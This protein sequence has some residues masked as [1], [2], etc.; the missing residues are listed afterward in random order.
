M[1]RN[2]GSGYVT[3]Q[4][5]D[6][7]SIHWYGKIRPPY[8]QTYTF[9]CYYDD[10]IRLYIDNVL[11]LDGWYAGWSGRSVNKALSANTF[12]DIKIEFA[13]G[14]GNAHW[15]LYWASPWIGMAIVP[16]GYLWSPQR[17]GDNVNTVEVQTFSLPNKCT[18]SSAPTTH[19]AGQVYSVTVQSRD[20]SSVALGTTS[21][22]YSITFTRS[23]GGGP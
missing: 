18:F 6:S 11:I 19:I 16:S 8:S 12:Y 23:D 22:S 14:G 7:V 17:V 2:W 20:S 10:R 4:R 9:T 21:D 5:A 1:Y 13:E 15:Y 3:S